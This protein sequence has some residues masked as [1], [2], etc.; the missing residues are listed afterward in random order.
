[1]NGIHKYNIT[2]HSVCIYFEIIY[3]LRLEIIGEE[4]KMNMRRDFRILAVISWY[5]YVDVFK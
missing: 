4:M 5:L 2:W 3:V 1:M